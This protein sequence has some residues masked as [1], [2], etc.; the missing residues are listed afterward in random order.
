MT[1]FTL[2]IGILALV[3]LGEVYLFLF[4]DYNKPV[5]N[6]N[7]PV[8]TPLL[9]PEMHWPKPQAYFRPLFTAAKDATTQ[10]QR[11]FHLLGTIA[12]GD[13]YFALLQAPSGTKV[14]KIGDTI[15][16]ARVVDIHKK[17]VVLQ[18]GERQIHLRLLDKGEF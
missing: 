14:V 3:F 2:T 6:D 9:F 7:E 11:G 17:D 1:R 15:D 16:G 13:V 12:E 8:I 10:L 4:T 5:S 18:T